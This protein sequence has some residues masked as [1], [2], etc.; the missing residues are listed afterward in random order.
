MG[1][2]EPWRGCGV[3]VVDARRR[4]LVPVIVTVTVSF[5]RQ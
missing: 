2:T 4:G 1:F 5:T 3:K